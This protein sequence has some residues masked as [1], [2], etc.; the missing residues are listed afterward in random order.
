MRIVSAMRQT[1]KVDDA[2]DEKAGEEERSRVD[3]RCKQRG[4]EDSAGAMSVRG[5]EECD[6][7][8]GERYQGESRRWTR[9]PYRKSG[10]REGE[11]LMQMQMMERQR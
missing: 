9:D 8:C 3:G 7:A 2:L 6:T 4:L 11:G 5:R 10:Q 1:G